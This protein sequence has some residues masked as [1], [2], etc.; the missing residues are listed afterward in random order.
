MRCDNWPKYLHKAI[1]AHRERPFK[2]GE[3][4]C[5]LFVLECYDALCGVDVARTY[6][7]SYDSEESAAEVLEALGGIEAVV[8]NVL[9]IEEIDPKLAQRGDIVLL[10]LK[11]KTLG[12]IDMS[13]QR[14]VAAS[15][16]GM[17]TFPRKLILKAWR[18]P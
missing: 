10:D 1:E 14:A 13:G 2:W 6:R 7:H 17:G 4:D 11:D 8:P 3:T 16:A 18:V 5:C 12:V 9:E 15:P